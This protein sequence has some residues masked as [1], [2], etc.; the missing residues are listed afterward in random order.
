MAKVSCVGI[1]GCSGAVGE[2]IVKS[3]NDR[4]FPTER[5]K[6]FGRSTA[7]SIVDAGLWGKVEVG[8]SGLQWLVDDL[9]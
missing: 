1:V 6:L 5:L 9:L 7:G 3:L 8:G 2:A 4:K